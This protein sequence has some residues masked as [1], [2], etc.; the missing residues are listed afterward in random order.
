[1]IEE[2]EFVGIRSLPKLKQDGFAFDMT[3]EFMS[4]RRSML[5][6]LTYEAGVIVD[7]T[8][9]NSGPCITKSVV[10]NCMYLTYEVSTILVLCQNRSSALL[11][12]LNRK[13]D[14][15]LNKKQDSSPVFEL[16]AFHW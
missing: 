9:P 10:P 4:T 6:W 13:L 7:V 5:S 1:M 16:F 2:T 14:V 15:K 3:L 12:A 8:T 11:R